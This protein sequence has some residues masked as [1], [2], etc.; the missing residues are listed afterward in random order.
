MISYRKN[1]VLRPS[2]VFPVKFCANP[3][4]MLE[5]TCYHGNVTFSGSFTVR[6]ISFNVTDTGG[7]SYLVYWVGEN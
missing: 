6:F 2:E 5:A 1:A 4:E 3:C 7:K